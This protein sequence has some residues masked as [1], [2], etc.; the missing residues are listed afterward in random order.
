MKAELYEKWQGGD[1]I[2]YFPYLW[3][4]LGRPFNLVYLDPLN[5]IYSLTSY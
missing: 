4:V 1:I 5:P 2:L 3:I